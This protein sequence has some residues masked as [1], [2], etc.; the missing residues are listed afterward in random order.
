MSFVSEII[1]RGKNYGIIDNWALDKKR[2]FRQV[3]EFNLVLAAVSISA[4][5]IAIGY[6][7]YIG[8]LIQIIAFFL[9][10]RGLYLV[11]SEKL[12]QARRLA[13]YTF[14]TQMFLVALFAIMPTN[15]KLF[16]WYSPV[17]ITFM[18]Y[19]VVA[20]LF[21][22]P[23]F[24]HMAVAFS[25]IIALQLIG[26]ILYRIGFPAFPHN[27]QDILNIIVCIYS[28]VMISLLVYLV[29]N[30]N[31]S[32][33]E[34]EIE[35]SK[36]L[37]KILHKLEENNSVIR[38][39]ADD[40]AKLNNAK[41][42]FFSIIA[43]DLKSPYNIVLNFSAIL[44]EKSINDPDYNIYARSLY[45][46]AL[47]NYNLL[48]NL[49]EWSRAQMDGIKVR[50]TI[51]SINEIIFKTINLVGVSAEK[52]RLE[53]INRVD[54]SLT[55][56]ADRDLMNV[57]IRNIITNAIKFTIPGG[58]III[59]GRKMGSLAEIII[60]DNGIGMPEAVRENLFRI[61]YIESRKGTGD[62]KGTGLGLILCKDFIEL[63]GG[64]ISVESEENKGSSFIFTVPLARE[65]DKTI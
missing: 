33:K 9:Y 23:V 15:I 18:S 36:E 24:K 46:T 44:K 61:D 50:H 22:K 38:Q 34:K 54:N 6:K 13:I 45:D 55:I 8:L 3:N 40:L 63:Q 60:E 43:H 41:N 2:A 37:E 1:Y 10:L 42:K 31:K 62:E 57:I 51:F 49:L 14:E 35:R 21:D 64:T 48:E 47:H 58:K 39:Q 20:A 27:E 65:G 7:V 28:I 16:P 56:R 30:E 32:V 17:F 26:E 5:P 53:I 4:W 25:Q 12:R 59:S 19:P 52:K 29:Y 11:K